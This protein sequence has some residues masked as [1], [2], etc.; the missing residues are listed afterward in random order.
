[1]L[2]IPSDTTMKM[3]QEYFIQVSDKHV[4]DG[5]YCW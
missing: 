1:M 4:N 3:L 5:G 2:N